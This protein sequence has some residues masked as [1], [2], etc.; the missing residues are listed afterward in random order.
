MEVCLHGRDWSMKLSLRGW[1]KL[2]Q[3]A[4]SHGWQPLGTS[5]PPPDR[6]ESSVPADEWVVWD[7]SYFRRHGQRVLDRDA[8]RLAEALSHALPHIPDEK[9][10]AP[11]PELSLVPSPMPGYREAQEAASLVEHMLAADL[12]LESPPNDEGKVPPLAYFS[13]ERKPWVREF[14]VRC[15]SGGFVIE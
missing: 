6:N 5:A 8:F 15:R 10:D 11:L 7:G 4:Y 9:P 12:G 1:M 14:I 3:L 2:L 13:G